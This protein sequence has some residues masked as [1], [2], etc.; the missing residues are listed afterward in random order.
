[1]SDNYYALKPET[2][3]NA[4]ERLELNP[5]GHILQLNSLE[6]RVYSLYLEDSSQIVIKIYRPGRWTENQILEEHSFLKELQDAEIP[7][8]APLSFEG[9]TIHHIEEFIYAIFPK[10]GGRIP[11]EFSDDDLMM[12]GRL[13][14]RIHNTGKQN[15]ANHRI[16]ICPENFVRANLD[17]M[18]QNQ[19]MPQR[20]LSVYNK[21]AEK[22]TAAFN[23][24]SRGIPFHRIH[25]DFHWG[26]LL[27]RDNSF[28]VLDF[29]DFVTG[30]AVQDIWMLAPAS[31]AEG[32]RKREA[33]LEGYREFA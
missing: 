26:N 32:Q 15:K 13:I 5:T 1:M 6:N 14:A 4:A 2:I 30:P 17:Y 20:Y 33:L 25:G 29:D 12:I 24:T 22:I 27:K 31:D 11:D 7:V 3:L 16:K 23:E 10:N 21:L 28:F 18:E 19:L 9:K 8:C